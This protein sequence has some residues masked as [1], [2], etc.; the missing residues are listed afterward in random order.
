MASANPVADELPAIEAL[1]ALELGPY[2][3]RQFM[4]PV[5]IHQARHAQQEAAKT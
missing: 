3:N 1:G 5:E 2:A 4:S